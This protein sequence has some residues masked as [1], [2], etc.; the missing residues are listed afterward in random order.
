MR[1][2][3]LVA[4][5]QESVV[6]LCYGFPLSMG[7]HDPASDVLDVSDIFDTGR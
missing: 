5:E 2:G 1:F 4:G 3:E 6:D 7:I